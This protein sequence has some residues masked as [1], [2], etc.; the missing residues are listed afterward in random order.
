MATISLKLST[1][2]DASGKCQVI[3]KLTI[4][5]T[6]RPCFKSGIWIRP[7]WFKVVKETAKGQVFGIVVPKRGKLNMIEVREAQDAKTKLEAYIGKLAAVSNA[8]TGHTAINHESIASAMTLM[9]ETDASSVSWQL[10]RDSQKMEEENEAK[11]N[12]RKGFFEWF[13][14]Y[15]QQKGQSEG[16]KRSVHVL[17]RALARYEKFVRE[18]DKE[19]KDFCL[20]ID[21]IDKETL[22]D[23][24]DYLANEKTLSEQYPDLFKGLLEEYPV[25]FSPKH[26]RCEIGERGKNNLID[27]KKQLK[28]FFNWLW[29]QGYTKNRPFDGITIGAAKYGTPYF[30]TNE[31]RNTIAEWDFCDNKNLERQRDI[32]IFQCLIGCR[33]SDLLKLTENNVVTKDGVKSIEYIPRKTKDEK[34][35]VVTVPLNTRA[36]ALIEKYKDT[37]PKGKLFPFISSQKYNDAI[38]EICSM[39]KVTRMVSVINSKT[40]ETEQIPICEIASS[41][42]ARRTFIG[43]LYKQVKDP[44]LIGKLSGHVEGSQAFLRYRDID[45]DMMRETV[46]LLD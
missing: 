28:A 41:H 27:R 37:S 42:M 1:R 26:R 22:E 11:Q 45:L 35:T 5:R 34:P 36:L 19:R 46:N 30:L 29:S 15:L 17:I 13:E 24:F 40:G 39:C 2:P 33:V 25:E 16:R 18:T 21:E 32:F 23:F 9:S 31:E 4:D 14:Y 7:E 8:L 38:K 43:N 44:N 3:V 10:I 6:N 12:N 20:S